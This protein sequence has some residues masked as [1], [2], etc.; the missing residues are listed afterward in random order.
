MN[1]KIYKQELKDW[2]RNAT[3]YSVETTSL[4][5]KILRSEMKEKFLIAPKHKK[6]LD[7]G[8]GVGDL[9]KTIGH[10]DR[11][12]VCADFS[13]KMR[14]AA[15][16]FNPEVNYVM[17]SADKLPFADDSFDMVIVCGTLHHLKT[18]GILEEGLGE[19]YRVLK[20]GGYFC[21]LDRFNSPVATLQEDA[22]ALM[23][24]L[25]S[26][27]REHYAACSTTAEVTL[28]DSDLE[29]I[30]RRYKLISRKPIYALPFKLFMVISHF[31]FYVCGCQFY[32][33]FQ[34]IFYPIAYIIEKYGNYWF[35]A[36]EM[37]EV[38][39]KKSTCKNFKL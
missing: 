6:I 16:N 36:T 31:L 34:R 20:K 4:F 7:L 33:G 8:A 18:Q 5:K 11:E 15:L 9:A 26:R 27:L 19:I 3:F 29:V 13:P 32:L 30:R 35:Y 14:R 23:K 10:S 22:F 2:N 39:Q 28:D 24:N 25:F 17:A 12:V 21:F 1:K 38:L 37:C